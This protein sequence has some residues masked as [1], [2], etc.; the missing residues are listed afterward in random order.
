MTAAAPR[1]HEWTGGEDRGELIDFVVALISMRWVPFASHHRPV[2]RMRE[3]EGAN[4][5]LKE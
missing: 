1:H 2:R 3:N 4:D 5:S